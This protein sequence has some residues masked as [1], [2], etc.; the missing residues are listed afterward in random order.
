LRVNDIK[1]EN[2]A[3]T[4]GWRQRTLR[5]ACL[6]FDPTAAPGSAARYNPLLEVR[7]WPGDVRDTQLI[8]DMLIDPDGQ[9]TRDHWDL[10]AH[11]LLVGVI[12]H[13]L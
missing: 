8:A 9:G 4:A 13:V 12:L 2:W 3:L 7:P 10:T 6:K 5:S 11:D 1:G